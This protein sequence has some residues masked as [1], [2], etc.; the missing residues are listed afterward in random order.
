MVERVK[1]DPL[2]WFIHVIRMNEDECMKN[3]TGQ[4]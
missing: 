3:V 4:G 2:K 1:H